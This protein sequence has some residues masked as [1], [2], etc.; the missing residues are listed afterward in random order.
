MEYNDEYYS[1]EQTP[2]YTR[3]DFAKVIERYLYNK[4]LTDDDKQVLS[5][6]PFCLCTA[7]EGNEKLRERFNQQ[8]KKLVGLKLF[9]LNNELPDF[10]VF[11]SNTKTEWYHPEFEGLL[12]PLE[13]FTHIIMTIDGE[14]KIIEDSAYNVERTLLKRGYR[15]IRMCDYNEKV[16][17]FK[18]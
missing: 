7:F 3:E 4:T 6:L 9:D 18:D 14:D 10:V 13:N 12:P 15:F 16:V 1:G 8:M 11:D 17:Y 2:Q 5:N